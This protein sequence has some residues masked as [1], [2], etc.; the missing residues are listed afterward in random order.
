MA[1][2]EGLP[3]YSYDNETHARG[4]FEA[5][6]Q[7]L[8]DLDNKSNNKNPCYNCF[9]Q[10]STYQIP[11]KRIG[12]VRTPTWYHLPR[13]PIIAV[14]DGVGGW[15][16]KGVNPRAFADEILRKTY[17]DFIK[18]GEKDPKNAISASFRTFVRSRFGNNLRWKIRFGRSFS[19]C[20]HWRFGLHGNS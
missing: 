7:G 6:Y 15:E 14:A 3:T 17:H 5:L 20:Q 8:D 18:S 16:S 19:C 4:F 13:T 11:A 9:Q 10:V 1:M 12:V 2:R